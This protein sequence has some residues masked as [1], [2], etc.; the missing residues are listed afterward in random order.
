MMVTCISNYM[1]CNLGSRE[2]PRQQQTSG[3][4]QSI[5]Q[6]K[7]I[8]QPEEHSSP[9]HWPRRCLVPQRKDI[10][11]LVRCVSMKRKILEHGRD[12]QE[13]IKRPRRT[14]KRPLEKNYLMRN[15]PEYPIYCIRWLQ[16]ILRLL[17]H[18]VQNIPIVPK[19][20]E[21]CVCSSESL[22]ISPRP[23]VSNWTEPCRKCSQVYF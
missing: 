21:G 22:A 3:I 8:P 11:S 12:S 16:K 10:F 17:T 20:I 13:P 5:N 9:Q 7:T 23:S 4:A 6:V 19:Q 1:C 15:L 2:T 14:Q 18:F